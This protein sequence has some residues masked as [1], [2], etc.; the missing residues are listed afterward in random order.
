MVKEVAYF[1]F[2]TKSVFFDFTKK[3][4]AEHFGDFFAI[5]VRCI[6]PFPH[7]TIDI[8]NNMLPLLSSNQ[9]R[10]IIFIMHIISTAHAR[11]SDLLS[12][13]RMITT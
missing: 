6:L 12:E 9:F 13:L 4:K 3:K 5:I 1:R 8:V 2:L 10:R 7:I 11:Y